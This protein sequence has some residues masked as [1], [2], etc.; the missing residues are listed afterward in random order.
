MC[1]RDNFCSC[2]DAPAVAVV[3]AVDIIAITGTT[4]R[5]MGAGMHSGEFALLLIERE[6]REDARGV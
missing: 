6:R 4:N 1:G 3:A 5:G 2:H